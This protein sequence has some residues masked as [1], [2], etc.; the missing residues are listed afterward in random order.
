MAPRGAGEDRRRCTFVLVSP[1]ATNFRVGTRRRHV[2]P[3]FGLHLAF[4][5]GRPPSN[6]KKKDAQKKIP[7]GHSRG[8]TDRQTFEKHARTRGSRQV[9]RKDAAAAVYIREL[10]CT[11]GK[12]G[13]REGGG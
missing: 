13:R 12:G 7:L 6:E 3:S 10:I 2:V 1:K 4:G 11:G 8:E 5:T 9:S